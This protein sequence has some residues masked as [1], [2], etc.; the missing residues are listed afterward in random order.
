MPIAALLC[1][2]TVCGCDSGDSGTVVAAVFS[3]TAITPLDQSADVPLTEQITVFFSRPVDPASVTTDSFRVVAESGDVIPGTRT[4]P[5]INNQ[6][7]RF[8]PIGSYFAFAVHRVEVGASLRD[9]TGLPLNQGYMFEFQTQGAGPTFPQ[10]SQ[11]EDLGN[12]LQTG[13]WLHRMTLLQT[14][15][16]LVTGGYAGVGTVTDRAENLVPSQKTS[17]DIVSRMRQARAGH[18][19]VLLQ[20]GRVLICGGEASDTPFLPL[21]VCE[22]FDPTTFTFS[23]VASMSFTRS[24]A[25]ATVLLDGRVL[26]TGG[27]GLEGSVFVF[28]DDAEIYDP[29]ADTWTPAGNRMSAVRSGHFTATTTGG[30][31]IVIGGVNGVA[32]A[33]LFE[34]ASETFMA[35]LTLPPNPHFFG[36][37]TVLP[38]GRPFLAGGSGGRGVTLF[39]PAF[40]FLS[41]VNDMRDERTFATAT[42]FLDG[43]VVIVGGIDLSAS[44]IRDTLDVWFPIGST[45]KV[46]RAPNLL[47]PRPTSHHAAE[48]GPGGSL[49]IVG[50]LP[51][52]LQDPGLRQVVILH[53]E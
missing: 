37:G 39:D 31:V 14:N 44:L 41:G 23:T 17:F 20:D 32:S 5:V 19:Q 1:A 51:L 4:V 47:L 7:I 28:R 48:L 8:V 24:L 43:R 27:Q 16:F 3:V 33:D 26:V 9:T 46:F 53:P 49:W 52:D 25:H 38:D 12:A 22:V 13:R 2:A 45:G 36:A 18:V 34:V 50:G 35:P 10:Q 30:N 42:A 11:V 15:R 6:Q 40:G 21:N 29:V